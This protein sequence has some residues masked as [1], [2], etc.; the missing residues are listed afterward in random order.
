MHEEVLRV[1]VVFMAQGY[2]PKRFAAAPAFPLQI[3]LAPT[4]LTELAIPRPAS[5][6]GRPLQTRH[7]PVVSYFEQ[8]DFSGLIDPR[9][10]GKTWKYWLDRTWG[11]EYVFEL[12]ADPREAHNLV[13]TVPEELLSDWRRRLLY[14]KP[15]MPDAKLPQQVADHSESPGQYPRALEAGTPT[16]DRPR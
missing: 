12:G 9:Q 4:I 16:P 5:W 2:K 13:S 7:A 8:R 15:A 1:P 14:D 6:K 11:H 3:D 10:R